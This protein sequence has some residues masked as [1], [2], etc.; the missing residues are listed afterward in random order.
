[1]LLSS[2]YAFNEHHHTA[3]NETNCLYCHITY[4]LDLHF[5]LSQGQIIKENKETNVDISLGCFC[6]LQTD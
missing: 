3:I 4:D 5:D 1:M 2:D 6:M